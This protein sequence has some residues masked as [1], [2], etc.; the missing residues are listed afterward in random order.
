[1]TCSR[2]NQSLSKQKNT[3]VDQWFSRVKNIT[4]AFYLLKIVVKVETKFRRL[5]L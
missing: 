5:N 2:T 1:M 4:C 3:C